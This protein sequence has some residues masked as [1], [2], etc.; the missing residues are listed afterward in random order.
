[1]MNNIYDVEIK[2]AKKSSDVI[3]PKKLEKDT[4]FDIFAYFNE[5]YIIVLPHQTVKIPTGIY[6]AFS[7]DYVVILKEKSST[8]SIGISQRSG[9]INSSDRGEWLIPIT[10][11]NTTPL[12]IAKNYVNVQ[13]VKKLH[14]EIFCNYDEKS[15]VQI[16]PYEKAICQAIIIPAP[17]IKLIEITYQELCS[18]EQ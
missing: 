4:G 13:E 2:F 16:Y 11:L 8:G 9:I 15:R 3:M 14:E 1:M 17:K 6:S 7:Q 18:L 10:N 5:D 12:I